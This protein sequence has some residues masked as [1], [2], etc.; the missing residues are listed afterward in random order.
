MG[1]L[2]WF[3]SMQFTRKKLITKL[4]SLAFYILL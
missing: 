1:K 4:V 2:N 3:N